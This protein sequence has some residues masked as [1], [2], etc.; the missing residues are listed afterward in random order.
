MKVSQRE[1]AFDAFH[2]GS[3]KHG[4]VYIIC[5]CQ[6]QACAVAVTQLL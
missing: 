6:M 5:I 2:M 4:L 1:S 3:Y